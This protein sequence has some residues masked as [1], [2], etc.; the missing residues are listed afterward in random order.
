MLRCHTIN[1]LDG[2]GILA[3]QESNIAVR[4]QLAGIEMRASQHQAMLNRIARRVKEADAFL[5]LAIAEKRGKIRRCP[6]QLLEQGIIPA[7]SPFGPQR[8][9]LSGGYP[10]TEAVVGQPHQAIEHSGG[11]HEEVI[12]L[13]EHLV[14][15]IARWNAVAQPP[16]PI[17]RLHLSNEAGIEGLPKLPERRTT[18]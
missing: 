5:L 16:D 13:I 7:W 17:A 6:I 1:G 4:D 3:A 12:E 8:H 9:I 2:L 18:R 14:A 11:Q 10:K 15:G